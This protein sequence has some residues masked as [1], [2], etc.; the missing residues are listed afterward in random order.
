MKVSDVLQLP[1]LEGAKVIAGESGINREVQHVNMMDA[2]DI[3]HFLNGDDLLVTTAYHLKDDPQ[4]LIEL[5]QNMVDQGCAG[6]GIKTQR[7]LVEVPESVRAFADGVD[8]PIIEIP[9]EVSLGEVVNQ[10]LSYILEMRTT[11]LRSAIETHQKFTDHI[12][13]GKGV[14]KLLE[15][16]SSMIEHKVLLL[17]HHF[18]PITSAG[19]EFPDWVEKMEE[20]HM[21]GFD[22]FLPGTAYSSF[23]CL[24]ER[25]TITIFPIKT[26]KNKG[27]CLVVSGDI[28]SSNR[29][30]ILTIEQ[31]TNVISFELMKESALK[32]YDMRARNEFFINFVDGSFSS[33][34]EVKNRAKEFD[35][36]NDQKYVCIIGKLDQ[37]GK[38]VSFTQYQME[39][40]S[41]YE[42]LEG[43]FYT[44]DGETH[45]FIKGDRCILLVEVGESWVEV[46]SSIL[47]YLEQAQTRINNRFQR[48]ISF[49]VGNI[50]QQFIAVRNSFKEA[51]NALRTGKLSGNTQFIQTYR[52][53]DVSEIL[54]IV[55]TEDLTEF[56]YHALQDLS[57]AD[58][59]EEQKFLH[60]LSV[61]LETHCQ[62][63][64]TAKKMYVHRNTVIYRLEKCEEL[65]GASLKDPDTTIR[66]RLALRVKT[67]LNL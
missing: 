47:S 44:F 32:Q 63:S 61:Y 34:E 21:D 8:F 50:S 66:L 49:G 57:T 28:L 35:L 22:F 16:L 7:F 65:L 58:G 27:G 15:D 38:D 54:S 53:K 42:F 29:S 52:T 45:L 26:Y 25:D 13:T 18:K 31:A 17:D 48:T 56:Y 10:T 14:R 1:V 33:E 24:P 37:D 4:L 55:P 3:V 46:D 67:L 64:Y 36:Y 19:G 62:I 60:T 11:E 20:M 9:I 30:N 40:D 23:T 5:I 59:K 2:P 39:A 6:L 51:M 41:I 12:I 43:E